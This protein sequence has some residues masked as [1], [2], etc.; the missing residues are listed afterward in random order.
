[1]VRRGSTY[2]PEEPAGM[3]RSGA[4][5]CG[6]GRGA[7]AAKPKNGSGARAFVV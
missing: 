4:A 2:E 5:G 6:F 7:R 3:R 1:M